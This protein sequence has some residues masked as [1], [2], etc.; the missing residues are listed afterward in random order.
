MESNGFD[1][2][3]A[4]ASDTNGTRL[5]RRWVSGEALSRRFCMGKRVARYQ[6]LRANPLAISLTSRHSG[7]TRY[8]REGLGIAAHSGPESPTPLRRVL[9]LPEGAY[10]DLLLIISVLRQY[11]KQ[12]LPFVLPLEIN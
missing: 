2:P 6:W 5:S 4:A 11:N 1:F 3:L 10:L 8:D 7:R 12:R 9:D